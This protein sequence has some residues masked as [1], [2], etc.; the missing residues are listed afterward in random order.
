[1]GVSSRDFL[2]IS[3]AAVGL[4]GLSTD[5]P[6]ARADVPRLRTENANV[7]TTVINK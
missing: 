7:T 5:P 3:G 1:M 6:L 2:K 4:S